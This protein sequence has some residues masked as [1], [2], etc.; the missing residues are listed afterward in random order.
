[1]KTDKEATKKLHDAGFSRNLAI[2][3]T[4][5]GYSIFDT[6]LRYQRHTPTH[7][8]V[9]ECITDAKNGLRPKERTLADLMNG[10]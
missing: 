2:N 10:D 9:E 3:K 6:R 5:N 1:M 4:E 7:R 8:T